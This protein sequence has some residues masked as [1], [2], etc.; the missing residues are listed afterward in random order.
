M[1]AKKKTRAKTTRIDPKDLAVDFDSFEGLAVL[2][3]HPFWLGLTAD[4]PVNQ[5]DVAG[6]HFPKAEEEIKINAAGKQIRNPVHGALNFHVTRQH[7]DALCEVLPRLVIRFT[8]K[9]IEEPP[10][11][12]AAGVITG[13]P[14]VVRRGYLVKIPTAAQIA[15][16]E[17]EIQRMGGRGRKLRPYMR[18][19]RDVPASRFMYF[20]HVPNKMRGNEFS[21]IEEDGLEWPEVLE[22]I[23][24]ILS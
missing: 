5:I 10:E 7:F 21:T 17:E 8:D 2:E 20:Q 16:R 4:C 18:D 11:K 13:A 24:E 12:D 9:G 15:E 19:P 23:D 1:A 14:L 3:E 6:L 22:E